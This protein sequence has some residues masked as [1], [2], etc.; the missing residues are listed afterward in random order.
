M[1]DNS[2]QE[3]F[4]LNSIVGLFL[5][6]LHSEWPKL[7]ECDRVK[8]KNLFLVVA[9]SMLQDWPLFLKVLII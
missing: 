1:K 2:Y 7:S 3:E 8:G 9:D 5:T 4:V 6:L